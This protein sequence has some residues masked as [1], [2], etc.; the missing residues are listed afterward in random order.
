VL[1]LKFAFCEH[2]LIPVRLLQLLQRLI[3]REGRRLLLRRIVLKG[4]QGLADVL[5]RGHH[6]FAIGVRRMEIYWSAQD[7][8]WGLLLIGLTIAIHAMG[9]VM[10]AIA[11]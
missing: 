2:A 8:T 6:A 10:M 5:L 9:V 4:H 3:N 7:W 1:S 11:G